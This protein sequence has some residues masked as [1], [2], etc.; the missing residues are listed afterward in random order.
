MLHSITKCLEAEVR[1]VLIILHNVGAQKAFVIVFKGSRCIPVKK[2]H[3]RLQTI[4][5]HFIY[6]VVVELNSFFI[7]PFA[8][9]S[10][11]YYSR[12]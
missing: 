11:W 9:L 5:F 6:K 4:L 1:E 7:Q 10:M 2:S 8:Y 3:V 12:P